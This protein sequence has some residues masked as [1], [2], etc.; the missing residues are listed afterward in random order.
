MQVLCWNCNLWIPVVRESQYCSV[1]SVRFAGG[2]VYVK[3]LYEKADKAS[4]LVGSREGA[5]LLV[6][7]VSLILVAIF[8]RG[9]VHYGLLSFSAGLF[10]ILIGAVLLL[11]GFV[12]VTVKS[13]DKVLE[14][15]PDLSKIRNWPEFL[16]LV[17]R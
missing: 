6:S 12:E 13:Y 17:R 15:Y 5:Y 14:C 3:D 10:F 8:F 11:I 4:K 7:L 16:R 1:C 2:D 9:L